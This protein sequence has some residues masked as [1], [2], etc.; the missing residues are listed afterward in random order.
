MR[1]GHDRLHPFHTPL[2]GFGGGLMHPLG[3]VKLPL[4]LGIEPHQTIIWQDFI[5]VDY[6]LPYNVILGHLTLEKI[7]VITFNYHLMMKFPTFTGIGEVRADQKVS[8]HC[9]MKAMKTNTA[10]KPDTK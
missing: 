10:V 3:W 2:V 9:F 1:I 5:V 8:R 4:I 7:K 6:S